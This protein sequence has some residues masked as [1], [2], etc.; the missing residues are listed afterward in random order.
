MRRASRRACV[1]RVRWRARRRRSAPSCGRRKARRPD[2]KAFRL[3]RMSDLRVPPAAF[4]VARA[5]RTLQSLAEKGF[6]PP[7]EAARALLTGAFGNS[8]FLSRLAL[9]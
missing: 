3:A 6:T 5:A 4:D 8:G 1:S 9:A 7:D 2:A